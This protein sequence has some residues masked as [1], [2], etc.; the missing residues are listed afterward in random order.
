MVNVKTL[1]P[2]DF[3]LQ[4][5]L[6]ALRMQQVDV[7]IATLKLFSEHG[8]MSKLATV[9]SNHGTLLLHLTIPVK[10]HLQQQ[11]YS[12]VVA[13][14]QLLSKHGDFPEASVLFGKVFPPGYIV[15][16]QTLL[17]GRPMG[18]RSVSNDT[19][20]DHYRRGTK[21]LLREVFALLA[22]LH[23]NRIP[24]YGFLIT[25]NGRIQGKYTTWEE[26]LRRDARRWLRNLHIRSLQREQIQQHLNM[27][28]QKHHALLQWKGGRLLH[29][30]MVNP[31][32]VLVE[33]GMITGI[34]DFEWA[35]SGDPAWEF[36]FSGPGN[37]RSYFHET[38]LRGD[39]YDATT[40]RK[41]IQLYRVLWLLWGANVHVKGGKLYSIL[42]KQFLR[43]LK[44]S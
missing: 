33:N 18:Y 40:F 26:F 32:N 21:Q 16:V 42:Y 15:T 17:P 4:K 8:F 37:L 1:F 41:K 35:L 2:V 25:K 9:E 29:G 30:D 14:S 20:L 3:P 24:G 31:S 12:K 6:T 36:A 44:K 11:T 43:E 7:F 28:F 34:V 27:F 5:L 10:E 19:I 23:H 39:L 13:V 22:H 38:R